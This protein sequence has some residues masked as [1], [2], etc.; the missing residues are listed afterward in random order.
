MVYGVCA[1]S[2]PSLISNGTTADS[3]QEK[4]ECLDSVFASKS[5]VP[6]PSLSVLTPSSRMHILLD[7]TSFS[8]ETVEKFLAILDSDTVTRPHVTEKQHQLKSPKNLLCCSFTFSFCSFHPIIC[9][10]SSSIG[11]EVN[12]HHCIT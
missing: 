5:S 7:F 9:P 11:L 1:P 6:N 12:Q 2:I 8:P 3:A 4:A 10:R